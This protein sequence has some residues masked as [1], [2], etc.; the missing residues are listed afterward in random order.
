MT[1]TSAKPVRQPTVYT[2]QGLFLVDEGSGAGP[3]DYRKITFTVTHHEGVQGDTIDVIV[4][5]PLRVRDT[6]D[7]RVGR[8]QGLSGVLAEIDDYVGEQ[9]RRA[10]ADAT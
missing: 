2:M 4:E 6:F 7:F 8:R 3:I 5:N 10:R 9:R 1:E